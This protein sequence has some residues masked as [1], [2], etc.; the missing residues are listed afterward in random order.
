MRL[1]RT[2]AI[3][4]EYG[5]VSILA[6]LR[7]ACDRQVRR[8]VVVEISNRDRQRRASHV[9]LNGLNKGSITFSKYNLG[10]ITLYERNI[11]LSISVEIGYRHRNT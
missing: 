5:N 1:E 7:T 10:E 4:E 2:I 3:S 6:L 9:V 11:L 8:A